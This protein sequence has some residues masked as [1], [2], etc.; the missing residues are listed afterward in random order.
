[1]ETDGVKTHQ[2]GRFDRSGG[3]ELASNGE[4]S[5]SLE[6]GERR[7]P[8][9]GR[10]NVV[11]SNLVVREAKF[12]VAGGGRDLLHIKLPQ[13]QLSVINHRFLT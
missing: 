3:L 7:T 4:R 1:M 8:L 5:D 9:A 10:R 6:N 12:V 2:L 11:D 13:T